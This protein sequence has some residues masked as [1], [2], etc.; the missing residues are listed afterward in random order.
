MKLRNNENSDYLK[1]ET[2]VK[3]KNIYISNKLCNIN[4]N[5]III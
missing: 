1:K 4:I 5:N 3:L 2:T